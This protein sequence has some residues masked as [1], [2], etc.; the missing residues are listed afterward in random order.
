[1]ASLDDSRGRA[2]E[3]G[4]QAADGG[5]SAGR[6]GDGGVGDL[7]LEAFREH[8]AEGMRAVITGYRAGT[9]GGPMPA[10]REE[11]A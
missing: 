1:M 2:E 9:D 4:R 10:D 6:R 7:A 11:A 5:R 3:L 8:G